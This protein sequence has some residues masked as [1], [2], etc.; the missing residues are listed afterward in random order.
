MRKPAFCV[1]KTKDG[2]QLCG[3]CV[4]GL[5]PTNSLGPTETGPRFKVAPERL[6]CVVTTQLN[7]ASFL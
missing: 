6:N 5:R 7:S 1:C 4:R 3:C 2:D